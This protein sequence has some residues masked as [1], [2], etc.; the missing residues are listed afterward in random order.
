MVLIL[1]SSGNT[2]IIKSI[3]NI[4]IMYQTLNSNTYVIDTWSME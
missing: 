1:L 3:L 2:S 4:S